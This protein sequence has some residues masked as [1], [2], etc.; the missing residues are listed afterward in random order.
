[1]TTSPITAVDWLASRRGE[2]EAL[3]EAI[4]NID[5]PSADPAGTNAVAEVLAEFLRRPGIAVERIP[6]AG[7]GDVLKATVAGGSGAPVILMGH[8]DTVFPNGTAAKRPFTRRGDVATGPGVADMKSG[9]VSG[10]FVLAALAAAG[11]APFPVTAIFTADEE[12]G[13]TASHAEIERT[14]KGARAVLNLEPGRASGNVVKARKGGAAVEIEIAGKAAHSGSAPQNGR[15]AIE[16][17]ARKIVRLHALT[18]Y[19]TGITANVGVIAGGTVRNMVAPWAK[20]ELDLRFVESAQWPD[21]LARVEAILAA[22]DV[23]GTTATW[24]VGAIFRPL[25]EKMS[26]D[27]LARYRTAAASL[28]FA[29]DGE[30][31]GGCADSGFTASLGIPSLCGL[32][33]VGDH[34]HTEREYSRLDTLVPRAQAVA[35][36]LLSLA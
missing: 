36:T 15:S 30:F 19:E 4:V 32:G 31:S 35:L 20:A 14:A 18:D 6:V 33:P 23:P 3:L 2:M 29:V 17:L 8:R 12:V 25:E 28:G 27:L 1:M 7:A 22:D 10:C 5:S 26:C 21:L 11:G 9:V 34:S 24:S 16:A 13:S